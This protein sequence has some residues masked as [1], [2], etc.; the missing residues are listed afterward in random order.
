M[1]G[2][3]IDGMSQL[4]GGCIDGISQL[5]RRYGISKL[6]EGDTQLGQHTSA[7]LRTAGG[8]AL[9]VHGGSVGG[10]QQ[11]LAP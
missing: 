1:C 5:Y 9:L 8:R 11:I 2:G 7:L 10:V 6:Y 4:H 3:C